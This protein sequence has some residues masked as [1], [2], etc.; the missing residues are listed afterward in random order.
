MDKELVQR[1]KK[2]PT[3][4]QLVN[5]LAM[6]SAAVQGDVLPDHDMIKDPRALNDAIRELCRA[7]T[8]LVYCDEFW[9]RLWGES[10]ESA[11]ELIDLGSVDVALDDVVVT[12]LIHVYESLG[13]PQETAITF[14]EEQ[15]NAIRASFAEISEQYSLQPKNHALLLALRNRL[16]DRVDGIRD[17]VCNPFRG[18]QIKAQADSRL[19]K[20]VPKILKTLWSII[21]GNLG[22]EGL[23]L[24]AEYPLDESFSALHM[25]EYHRQLLKAFSIVSLHLLDVQ[26]NA[27]EP[28]GAPQK[29]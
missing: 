25:D 10:I 27:P 6:I 5:V 14:V 20:F 29:V 21:T 15:I 17:S 11:F 3:D 1:L 26:G 23:A 19:R 28:V 22:T 13:M 12:H 24:I 8:A 2:C 4:K 9:L 16:K 18:G 7:L